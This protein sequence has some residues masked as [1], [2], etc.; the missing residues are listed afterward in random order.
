MEAEWK[1]FDKVNDAH[2]FILK[3]IAKIERSKTQRLVGKK[4]SQYL[5]ECGFCGKPTQ[6]SFAGVHLK[7]KCFVC[8]DCIAKL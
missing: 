5:V 1:I 8:F 3:A 4:P 2:T 7:K 6:L